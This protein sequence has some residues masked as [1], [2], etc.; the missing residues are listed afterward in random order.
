[1]YP[2]PYLL[3]THSLLLLPFPPSSFFLSPHQYLHLILVNEGDGFA[4]ALLIYHILSDWT[5]GGP[6]FIFPSR[7]S[8][9]HIRSFAHRSTFSFL[10]SPSFFRFQLTLLPVSLVFFSSAPLFLLFEKVY[11]RIKNETLF[12]PGSQHFSSLFLFIPGIQNGLTLTHLF[13]LGQSF[14]LPR[15]PPNKRFLNL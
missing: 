7:H 5:C 13:R 1:M 14:S 3:H 2:Y 12:F 9:P 6:N 15:H 10:S 4:C 8:H 11:T